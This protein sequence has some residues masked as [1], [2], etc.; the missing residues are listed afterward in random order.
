MRRV[1]PLTRPERRAF[2]ARAER[3]IE[4]AK[5]ISAAV[6]ARVACNRAGVVYPERRRRALDRRSRPIS[7]R[8]LD[9]RGRRRQD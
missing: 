2:F 1:V 3:L 5:S 7:D 9:L 8:R 6:N 4:D